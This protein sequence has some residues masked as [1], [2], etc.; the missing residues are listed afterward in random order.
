MKKS[1]A[2]K[3]VAAL[4]SGQYKQG[5]KVLRSHDNKF[6][7][8]GVLCNLHAQE[9]PEFAAMQTDP[10]RYD[11]MGSL[12]PKRVLAWSGLRTDTA[13]YGKGTGECL[14]ALNDNGYT[15]EEI[16]NIIENKYKEL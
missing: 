8:L 4:R 14:T 13:D 10:R 3:W 6:C 5:T 16:A 9:H 2:L 7:C 11:M 1:I 12:P 15:F